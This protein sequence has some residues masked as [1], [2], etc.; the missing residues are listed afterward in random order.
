VRGTAHAD[1]NAW[2]GTGKERQAARC[3]PPAR[4]DSLAEGGA[5]SCCVSV[6]LVMRPCLEDDTL[7][8]DDHDS[9]DVEKHDSWSEPRTRATCS[10]Q[11]CG[12]A[13]GGAKLAHGG[14]HGKER[15]MRGCVFAASLSSRLTR[16]GFSSAGNPLVAYLNHLQDE[17]GAA[18]NAS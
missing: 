7:V 3:E 13:A 2:N 18:F 11:V 17:V 1:A 6:L 5:E 16:C 9:A 4:N 14:N 12:L 15:G 10:V 8:S